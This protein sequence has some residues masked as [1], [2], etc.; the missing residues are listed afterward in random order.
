[1]S[2]SNIALLLAAGVVAGIVG[3]A[4]GITSILSY[5]ALLLVGLPAMLA[6]VTNIV[7][8]AACWP[9][10]A[11]AS[12][13]ELHGRSRWL[14]HW[15]MLTAVGGAVGATLLLTTPPDV[16]VVIVPFLVAAG[17]F[18]LLLQPRIA[19]WQ[20]GRSAEETRI[21]LPIGIFSVAVYG[22]YFGA[23]AGVMLLALLMFSVDRHLARANALKNMLSGAATVMSGL[24]FA[25]FSPVDWLAM[26]PLA[27]GL[28][29]GSTIGPLVARTLPSA[30]LRWSAALTGFG[31]ALHLLISA[32]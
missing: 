13:A 11:V 28:F 1:M 22:G 9:G 10:S 5:P 12:R 14:R 17:S 19:T 4:G 21:L 31:L 32:T 24:I 20:S 16:F 27:I 15:A 3:T 6:N 7:A 25:F 18:G 8:L 26:V 2:S 23:G 30:L 29:V